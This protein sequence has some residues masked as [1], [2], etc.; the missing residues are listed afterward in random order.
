VVLDFG[1]FDILL[2]DRYAPRMMTGGDK[3][4]WT[5]ADLEALPDD[6]YIHWD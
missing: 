6:G 4:Q 1:P 2:V 5:E 3:K